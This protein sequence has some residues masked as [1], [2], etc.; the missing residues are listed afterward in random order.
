MPDRPAFLFAEEQAL[1]EALKSI[2]V[3]DN[4]D[5][6]RRVKVYYGYPNEEVEQ[7]YPFLTIDLLGIE[8]DAERASSEQTYYW[9]PTPTQNQIR[10]STDLQYFPDQ[11][12]DTD[13]AAMNTVQSVDNFVPVLLLYQV[14]SWARNPLHDRQIT[15]AMVRYVFPSMGR[16]TWLEVPEDGTI[17]RMNLLSWRA[18]DIQDQQ[19]G[20]RKAIH[21]KAYTI[22]IQAELPQ[23]DLAGSHIV[24]EVHGTISDYRQPFDPSITEDFS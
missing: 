4:A 20:Y 18:Q 21:R 5:P 1:R 15:G 16:R 22:S 11:Y 2:T 14:T 8:F 13:L 24:E 19:S 10:S 9:Q 12:S 3:A 17:R 23:I 7:V 6:S